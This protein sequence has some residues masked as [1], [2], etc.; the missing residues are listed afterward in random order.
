MISVRFILISDRLD[1]GMPWGQGNEGT[2][3]CFILIGISGFFLFRSIS[4]IVAEKLYGSSTLLIQTF[5]YHLAIAEKHGNKGTGL[6]SIDRVNDFFM[7]ILLNVP[8][9]QVCREPILHLPLY[10]WK[11]L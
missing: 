2:G 8:N 3:S 4:P 11:P 1:V 6:C 5:L 7:L 10:D 9:V